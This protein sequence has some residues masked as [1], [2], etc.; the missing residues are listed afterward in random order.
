M[1]TSFVLLALAGLS[2]AAPYLER[3]RTTIATSTTSANYFQISPE[4]FAG[5]TA[6]GTAPF[7]AET[8]P[9]PFPASGNATST[10]S[11]QAP[12]PLETAEPITG[13]VNNSN[14][15]QLMGNLSPYFPNPSGF[16]INEI[17]LP[18]GANISLVNML[19]RHGSRYPTTNSSQQKLGASIKNATSMGAKFTGQLSFL[20]SWSYN[21]GAEILVPKGR[22]ELFDSGILHYYQYAQLYNYNAT[23]V[24]RTTTE[25]RMLKSAENFLA[26]FVGLE[27]AT[28]PLVKLEPILEGTG[29]NDS[30]AGYDNCNNSNLPVSSGGSNAST[31]WEGIYLTNATARLQAM[32]TA[33]NWTTSQVY[34]AQGLCPYETIAF[35]FS[36]FCQLFT[37]Q[38][39]Q[40][41]EYSIDLQFYGGDMFGSP[42]GR[43]V[44]IGYVQ[45]VLG[46]LQNH[47]ITM[48]VTQDNITLD[49]NTISFP[50]NQTLYFDFSHDTNI[51]SILT[52]F[53]LTQFAQF[54]PATGP[55]ANQQMI[56]SH[57]EPFGARLD[58]EIIDAPMPVSASRTNATN[59]Y[60]C[61]NGTATQYIH[62]LLNQR[63]I[64]LG[65]S[66]PNCGNRT[67]GWCE[68]S[69]FLGNAQSLLAAA[70]YNYSCNGNY[71]AV[72]YGTITNGVP[73][74]S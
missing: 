63:T 39:W 5:P 16:G 60:S 55:P 65:V 33:F 31:I 28:N 26:G 19:S 6:T 61:T 74:S 24:A 69:T 1:V 23:I 54:L 30:L 56:V 4:V 22:Q 45:E 11:Y 35:G 10:A 47:T 50:L 36:E 9:A 73:Q 29:F 43:A 7:L 53:G 8:N 44:G 57:M 58:V 41:F 42:T 13:N 72:P 12:N 14:I 27:W 49:N 2:Q 32:T 37:Y 67:D 34:A 62:F 21:L 51:A 17:G 20:N 46:R 40:G 52:A 38:E 59:A 68:L 70:Q 15:F 48:P 3:R 66:Y 71:P 64:P 25:D 18:A